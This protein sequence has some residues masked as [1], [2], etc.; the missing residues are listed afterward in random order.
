MIHLVIGQNWLYY[1]SGTV[2]SNVIHRQEFPSNDNGQLGQ[3][4]VRPVI[5]I[6][7]TSFDIRNYF[8]W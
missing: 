4:N 3:L 5:Q 8:E 2:N 6:L 7:T 1:R